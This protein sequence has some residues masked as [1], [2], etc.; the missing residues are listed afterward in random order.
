M[1]LH[2]TTWVLILPAMASA[3]SAFLAG[4]FAHTLPVGVS[5]IMY[6][7]QGQGPEY[8]IAIAAA[9]LM[10]I[11]PIIAFLLMQKQMVRGLTIG[12]LKG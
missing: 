2:D 7:I 11:V 3:C 10:S 9:I 5:M 1:G 4:Q 12:A 8:G 6:Q